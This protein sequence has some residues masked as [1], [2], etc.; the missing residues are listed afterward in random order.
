MIALDEKNGSKVAIVDED[1]IVL[2]ETQDA[3]DLIATA[4]HTLDCYKLIIFKENICRE[5]FDLKTQIAG[6]IL[7]KF[8]NYSAKLAIVGDFANVESKALREFIYECNNG[9]QIFFLQTK[10]EALEK[11]HRLG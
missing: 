2:S 10:E 5:F 1:G 4:S 7:Q 8:T 9:S 11:L 3:L 6:E